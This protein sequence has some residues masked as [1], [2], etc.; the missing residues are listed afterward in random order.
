MRLTVKLF[1]LLNED[2]LAHALVLVYHFLIEFSTARAALYQILRPLVSVGAE[3][4]SEVSA[5]PVLK[6]RNNLTV[7]FIFIVVMP[8][9][10][11]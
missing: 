2:F 7:D 11:V 8:L 9:A 1:P 10:V 5:F 6:S 3:V 4:C